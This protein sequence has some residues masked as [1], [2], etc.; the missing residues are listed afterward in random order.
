MLTR[1]LKTSTSDIFD[2]RLLRRI[3]LAKAFSCHVLC[4]LSLVGAKS[5]D[6]LGVSTGPVKMPL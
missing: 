1:R 4:V 6:D 2:F 3:M 5:E